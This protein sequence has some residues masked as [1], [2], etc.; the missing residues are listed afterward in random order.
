LPSPFDAFCADAKEAANFVSTLNGGVGV[1]REMIEIIMKAL[2]EW[3]R[4]LERYE[5]WILKKFAEEYIIT[6]MHMFFQ[7]SFLFYKFS[8]MFS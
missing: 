2:G 8:E 4:V 3:K 5:C 1:V 7:S 6:T